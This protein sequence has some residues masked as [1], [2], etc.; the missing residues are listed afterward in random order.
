MEYVKGCKNNC[1][2]IDESMVR[3]KITK[4]NLLRTKIKQKL[5]EKTAIAVNVNS[6]TENY[7]KKLDSDLAIFETEYVFRH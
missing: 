5:A 7:T 6:L 2:A 3:E 1:T 4:I